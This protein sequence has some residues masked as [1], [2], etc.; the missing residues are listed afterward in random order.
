MHKKRYIYIVTHYCEENRIQETYIAPHKN[1]Y[2]L[3]TDFRC[4]SPKMM[5]IM[6]IMYLYML[7]AFS[8]AVWLDQD[9]TVNI[10]TKSVQNT[11]FFFVAWPVGAD[12]LVSFFLLRIFPQNIYHRFYLQGK[13][14]FT[15]NSFSRDLPWNIY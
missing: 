11:H 9:C 2:I 10:T 6:S 12:G 14:S 1:V 3:H 7:C 15:P 8:F 4:I 5:I 13:L